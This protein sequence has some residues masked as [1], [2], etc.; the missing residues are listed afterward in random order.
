M[1]KTKSL[2]VTALV[3]SMLLNTVVFAT[4]NEVTTAGGTATAVIPLEVEDTSGGSS[5]PIAVFSA[6]VPAELPIKM[7]LEGDIITPSNAMIVNGV[8]TKGIAVTNINVTLDSEWEAAGWEDD[9][10][11]E[12]RKKVA[13]QFRGDSLQADGSFEI[14]GANWRIPKDSYIDLNMGAK[15]PIQTQTGSMGNIATVEFTLDWSGDDDT[16]GPA[17][18]TVGSYTLTVTNGEHGTVT[19]LSNITVGSD[20]IITRLPEVTP[21]TGYELMKWINAD[22]G[23]RVQVGD[24]VES[25]ITIKPVFTYVGTAVGVTFTTTNC[26]ITSG[27]STVSVCKGS[28][29][30]SIAIPTV[31]ATD[32]AY[33][34][35]GYYVEDVKVEDGYVINADVTVEIRYGEV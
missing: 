1:N 31:E 32:V 26:N 20:G 9:F 30:G 6:Y 33:V 10:S 27:E 8:E 23:F 29:L 21:D 15:L 3:A 5:A 12:N 2:I 24:V 14:T 34:F 35:K 4:S 22:T 19:D 7:D 28:T 25:N 16:T 18:P 11:E 13:L 17:V